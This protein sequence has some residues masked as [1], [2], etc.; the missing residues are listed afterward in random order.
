MAAMAGFHSMLRRIGSIYLLNCK[1]TGE[2]GI[3]NP[4]RS[5]LHTPEFSCIVARKKF[6]K[7]GTLYYVNIKQFNLLLL[8]NEIFSY[9][10]LIFII[11]VSLFLHPV[12][13]FFLLAGINES[14]E[15]RRIISW[16]S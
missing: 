1:K 16:Q 3:M 10:L 7:P 4:P 11:F 12:D 9:I 14:S 2:G 8:N 5:S 6:I 13:A 15:V